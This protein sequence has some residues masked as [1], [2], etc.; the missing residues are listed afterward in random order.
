[1]PD[2]AVA[3]PAERFGQAL[4][5]LGFSQYE[6]RCYVGLL[7]PEPQTGY[8][9]AKSTGVPQPKVYETLRK[10]VARGAARQLAGE[11][12]R[13]VAVPPEDLLRDL[14]SSFEERVEHA[15]EISAALQVPAQPAAQEDVARLA[16]RAAVVA[17]AAD[18]LAR[19]TRRVYLSATSE[20]LESLREPVTGCVARGVAVV[21]LSFGRRPYQVAGARVFRHAS[22]DGA[23]YRHHQARHLALVADSRETVFGLAAD[24]AAWAGV[25]TASRPIIAAVKGYIRH[26]ID[27]QQ[28]YRDFGPALVSAYGPGLQ[29]LESYRADPPTPAD[30]PLDTTGTA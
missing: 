4:L 27:L 25:R 29:R 7:A 11:P 20:E 5:A 8:A 13:F 15:R 18:A 2:G 23:L 14:Q 3:S 22:T 26:D 6:A 17:A 28:V 9:V 16:D 30:H 24:G 1:M 19:A 12:A 10:L 21:V